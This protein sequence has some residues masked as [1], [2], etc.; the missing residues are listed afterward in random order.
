MKLLGHA[1]VAIKA[2]PRGNRRLLILGSILPEIMYYTTNH[3]FEKSEIHEGGDIVYSYLKKEKPS[4]KDL[5]LG[6]LSHSVKMGADRFNLDDNLQI[7]GYEGKKVIELRKRL[8]KVLGISYETAKIRAH[9]ILELAVEL[10]IIKENPEFVDEFNKAIDDKNVR[11]EIKKILADCFNKDK[12]KVSKSVD[13]LLG[14]AKS[15]YFK[16]ANGLSTLWF[17]L[18]SNFDPRF[19]TKELADLLKKLHKDYQ[20]KDKEFL[21]KCISWTKGNLEEFNI[22]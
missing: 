14:K 19:D 1:W 20:G 2:A 11:T 12:R 17:E 4:W 15:Q 22:N 18:T 16:D 5:G 10:R 6:M 7:L 13:E 21:R 8:M 3:P 9:N